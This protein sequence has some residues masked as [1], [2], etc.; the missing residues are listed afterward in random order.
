MNG[1]AGSLKFFAVAVF[2]LNAFSA[3][4]LYQP[5]EITPED[6]LVCSGYIGEPGTYTPSSITYTLTNWQTNATHVSMVSNVSWL[7]VPAEQN[8]PGGG[9]TRNIS[10]SLNAEA[11]L[12]PPGFYTGTIEFTHDLENGEIPQVRLVMLHVKVRLCEAVD[13][14]DVTWTTGGDAE[15]YGQITETSDA[16]DAAQ[17]GAIDNNQATWLET[18][19]YTPGTVSFWWKVSSEAEYAPLSFSINGQTVDSISGNV[20]WQQKTVALSGSDPE[21]QATGMYVLRWTY[22]KNRAF[23]V[24]SDSGWVDQVS[25]DPVDALMVTPGIPLLYQECLPLDHTVLAC[26]EYTIS[27]ASWSEILDWDVSCDVD[28]LTITP[29]T[30]TVNT[31]SSVQV[32]ACFTEA[33][34]TLFPDNNTATL[35]FKNLDTGFQ[36][37]RTVNLLLSDTPPP[38]PS[39][40]SPADS[41]TEVSPASAMLEWTDDLS[42]GCLTNYT[43]YFGESPDA[44]TPIYGPG[45]ATSM[46][47]PVLEENTVYFWRVA[48]ENC[49]GAATESPTWTFTTGFLNALV[50]FVPCG[51]GI[52]YAEI[53]LLNLGFNALVTED[54]TVFEDRLNDVTHNWEIAIVDVQGGSLSETTL[55]ALSSYYLNRE[56]RIIFSHSDLDAWP[57]QSHEFLGL[58][59]IEWH[60]SYTDAK[61]IYVWEA[62]TMFTI[63]NILPSILLASMLCPEY[64]HYVGLR[65][66]SR[67]VAGYTFEADAD[68]AAIIVNGDERIVINAFRPQTINGDVNNNGIPDMVELYEN[69]IVVATPYGCDPDETAPE[70]TLLGGNPVILECGSS[71]ESPGVYAWDFCDGVLSAN[72]SIDTSALNEKQTGTYTVYYS[73]TDSAGNPSEVLE[74]TVEVVDTT[75]PQISLLGSELAVLECGYPYETSG[76]FAWDDCDGIITDGVVIDTSLLDIHTPGAYIVSYYVTDGA[77]NTS[78][79]LERTVGVVDTEA[80]VISLL[81]ENPVTL[82]CGGAYSEPG[83]TATDTCEG[84]LSAGVTIDSTAVNPAVP[85]EYQV[86]YEITDNAGNSAEAIRE[87]QVLDTTAPMITLDTFTPE[88]YATDGFLLREC[89]L[90]F[91]EPAGFAATDICHGDLGAVQNELPPNTPGVTAWA[92]A[93]DDA[94]APLWQDETPVLFP[95]DAFTATLGDYL[96][97]YVAIDPS[98]N[99]YPALDA[100]GLPPIFDGE[101][102][103]DF[104]DEDGILKI[105]FARLV[106]VEDT[107]A[108][109][110]TLMGDNPL[111]LECATDYVSPG[112][113]A[114]DDCDGNIS[115][116]IVVDIS[117]MNTNAVGTYPVR[118]SVTDASGNP[119]ETQV[120][121][122]V[123]EDTTAPIITL[124]GEAEITLECGTAYVEPGADAADSCYGDISGDI[125]IGGDVVDT[126][127]AGTY[128]LTYNVSDG[129]GNAAAQVL[130]IV[131]IVDTTAPVVALLG[132]AE[133]TVECG[134]VFTDPGATAM[135]A[136]DGDLTAAIIVSGDEV[137][138]NTVGVYIISYNVTDGEG[139]AAMTVTRTV[140]VVDTLVPL[141]SLLGEAHVIVECT[142]PFIDPGVT[143]AD[144]C[145]GDLTAMVVVDDTSVDTATVGEYTVTYDVTDG[146][147]NAAL[148]VTRTVEVV[149]T[150][151]PVI[152]LPAAYV[153]I[154]CEE[155]NRAFD[156]VADALQVTAANPCG[157]V[158]AQ[159][160]VRE[161]KV[162]YPRRGDEIT[163]TPSSLNTDLIQSGTIPDFE[164]TYTGTLDETIQVFQ[165]YFI[166]KPA[167][168]EV[169]YGVDDSDAE[170]VTQIIRIDDECRGPL[171]CYSCDSCAGQRPLPEKWLFWKRTLGDLLLPGIALLTL[172]L[173]SKMG[174]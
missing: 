125:I 150:V 16:V 42:G 13:N 171:G 113:E 146:A 66:D 118:Y 155:F 62:E 169:T 164:G 152:T 83:A 30:G 153:P 163:Y 33:V 115:S 86:I 112:A 117:E 137:D 105:D 124:R 57:E 19:Y 18:T 173:F 73:V 151:T 93:L 132:E 69:Q 21:Y 65:G 15:W 127:S 162:T 167:I 40:L 43:L 111:T 53:A 63:P 147:G 47:L 49:C 174:K 27:N 77:G 6:D 54:A 5:V 91:E 116:H 165:Y 59:G 29:N 51:G 39:A 145:D 133:I 142:D 9:T 58:A 24:G 102:N 61:N 38:S 157:D 64:G 149:N 119:A 1:K 82:E 37:K 101:G 2:V 88:Q 75:A 90:P 68:N 141:I 168:Y 92:W 45:R 107:T 100:D 156:A 172:G 103:P 161:I 104:L 139:H 12:L 84:D 46:A 22:A 76:V 81:G 72:V 71:Y 121:T 60:D 131:R 10:V 114:L 166:F 35:V 70:I 144:H 25:F 159:I 160:R 106:R 85:G 140:T 99:T 4:G 20:N 56:G 87:V 109:E 120:R 126:Q 138:A 17:S 14:C 11:Y 32:N 122:V 154:E 23:A 67:A 34:E 28:W 136:C 143:A 8:V 31:S 129:S 74:R 128:I 134:D 95:Y 3:Y 26:G 123:V 50:Y 98:G 108:P 36:V 44:M 41:A 89:S 78:E 79:V 96:L 55:D 110:I 48:A 97:I 130:R 52:D 80:P 94:G 135:D 148:T 170:E 7:D 158:T